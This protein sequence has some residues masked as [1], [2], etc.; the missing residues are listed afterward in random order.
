MKTR[1][2]LIAAGLA[3]CVVALI[4][5]NTLS[6]QADVVTGMKSQGII[7]YNNNTPDETSDDAYFDSA[8]L[9]LLENRI[10]EV[11]AKIAA[12]EAKL[13]LSPVITP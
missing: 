9:I 6:V 1:N 4:S 10:K 8:D 13:N 5:Q 2:F 12:L 7:S 3:L 11:E